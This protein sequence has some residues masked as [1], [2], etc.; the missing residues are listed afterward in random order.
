MCASAIVHARV[1]RVV[2]GNETSVALDHEP[3]RLLV[4]AVDAAANVSA[5][6][7]YRR[8]P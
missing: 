8:A 4:N 2:F 5:V 1:S 3:L 6:A 7:E